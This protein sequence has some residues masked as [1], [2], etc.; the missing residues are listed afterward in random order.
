MTRCTGT[1]V[2]TTPQPH[3]QHHARVDH[4]VIGTDRD[5]IIAKNVMTTAAEFKGEDLV[6]VIGMLHANGVARYLLAGVDPMQYKE[7]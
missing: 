7:P 3:T 4:Q 6:V 5:C 2:T 1:G